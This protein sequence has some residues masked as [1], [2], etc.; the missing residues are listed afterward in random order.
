MSKLDIFQFIRIRAP[1]E[2]L[3]TLLTRSVVCV[4]GLG[5]DAIF[6]QKVPTEG[7]NAKNALYYVR[8]EVRRPLI[9]RSI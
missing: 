4:R 7:R 2:N 6:C 3:A 1:E 8:C 5:V 9:Y